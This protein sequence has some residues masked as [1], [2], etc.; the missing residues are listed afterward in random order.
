MMRYS[1]EAREGHVILADAPRFVSKTLEDTATNR[2]AQLRT[3]ARADEAYGYL[4]L[5]SPA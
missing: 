1:V 2:G 5:A 3:T 4:G